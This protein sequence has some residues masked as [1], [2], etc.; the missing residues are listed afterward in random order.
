MKLLANKFKQIRDTRSN[1]GSC[2]KFKAYKQFLKENNIK[3]EYVTPY[4][5]TGNGALEKTI[6][7]METYLKVYKAEG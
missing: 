6:G 3:P 2:F 1:H 5:L 7:T 4:V